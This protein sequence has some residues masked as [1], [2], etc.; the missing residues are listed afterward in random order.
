MAADK[1]PAKRYQFASSV[2]LTDPLTN[3]EIEYLT[4]SD[5]RAITIYTQSV[6]DIEVE[7]GHLENASILAVEVLD[8]SPP[9]ERQIQLI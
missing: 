7:D 9:G 1:R 6:V 5:R 2:D 8:H 4:V 3:F